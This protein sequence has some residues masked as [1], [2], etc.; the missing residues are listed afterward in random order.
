MVTVQR[1][2]LAVSPFYTEPT[3]RAQNYGL[4]WKFDRSHQRLLWSRPWPVLHVSEYKILESGWCALAAWVEVNK[5]RYVTSLGYRHFIFISCPDTYSFRIIVTLAIRYFA[6][7]NAG[8]KQNITPCTGLQAGTKRLVALSPAQ[9]STS[10]ISNRLDSWEVAVCF[11]W[12][13]LCWIN[14]LNLD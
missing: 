5:M 4:I 12:H 8:W 6:Y 11:V 10:H 3:V 2:A 14:L 9:P 1:R 13:H 7:V